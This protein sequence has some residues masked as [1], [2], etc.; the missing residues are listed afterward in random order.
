MRNYKNK[1]FYKLLTMFACITM[2]IALLPG[3]TSPAQPIE[4]EPVKFDNNHPESMFNLITLGE[5]YKFVEWVDASI[6]FRVNK[7]DGQQYIIYYT[8]NTDGAVS[9]ITP[10]DGEKIEAAGEFNLAEDGTLTYMKDG[11]E[12]DIS[13]YLLG[14]ASGGV[15][16]FVSWEDASISYRV[17]DKNNVEFV[18]SYTETNNGEI[19]SGIAGLESE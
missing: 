6:A 12:L 5:D 9:G 14:T 4:T 17:V 19:I 2:L 7:D 11:Q 16:D 3:C 8:E 1:S 13:A 10:I 18:I 15:F